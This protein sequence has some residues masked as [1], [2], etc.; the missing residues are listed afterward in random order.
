MLYVYC[1]FTVQHD[2][3][4]L[5]NSHYFCPGKISYSCLL[6]IVYLSVFQIRE[7]DLE[8]GFW[9]YHH[10]IQQKYFCHLFIL[11]NTLNPLFFQF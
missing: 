6:K 3:K 5:Q 11:K 10:I 1:M 2:N 8:L 4:M 7:L 9:N